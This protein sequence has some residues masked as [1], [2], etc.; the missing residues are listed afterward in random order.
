MP[1]RIPIKDALLLLLTTALLRAFGHE[2][3][4]STKGMPTRDPLSSGHLSHPDYPEA[5]FL[6]SPDRLAAPRGTIAS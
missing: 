2:D 4:R 6:C 1:F 5:V 3:S